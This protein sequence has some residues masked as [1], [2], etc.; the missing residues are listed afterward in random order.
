VAMITDGRYSGATRGPC[1]GH[2]C[3]EAFE[4]GP[5][6]IVQNGDEVEIDIDNRKL[7]LLLPQEE[8]ERRLSDWERPEANIKT[9]YLNIYRKIVSSAKYGAYLK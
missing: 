2:V 3:P 4:G 1:I 5:I 9:G 6:A 8:I 7:D